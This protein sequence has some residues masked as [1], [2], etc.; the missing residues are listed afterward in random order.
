MSDK[1]ALFQVKEKET[2]LHGSIRQK[3]SNVFRP[4]SDKKK[5][6]EWTSATLYKALSECLQSVPEGEC[7]G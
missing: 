1:T 6:K 5:V 2:S 3:I 7:S 4:S